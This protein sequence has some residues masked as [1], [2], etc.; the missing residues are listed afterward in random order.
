MKTVDFCYHDEGTKESREDKPTTFSDAWSTIQKLS[1]YTGTHFCFRLIDN[2]EVTFHVIEGPD[3]W[4]MEINSNKGNG[5]GR[6]ISDEERETII[7]HIYDNNQKEL[8]DG[9]YKLTPEDFE[10]DEIYGAF[11]DGLNDADKRLKEE[12]E[13]KLKEDSATEE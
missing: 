10:A 12:A 3:E 7:K 2:F 13:Q 5:I 1:P 4:L 9:V 11:L 6:F 8:L